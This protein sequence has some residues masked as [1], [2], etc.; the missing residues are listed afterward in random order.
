M[1]VRFF[2]NVREQ[3]EINTNH[4]FIIYISFDFFKREIENPNSD[5][6]DPIASASKKQNNTKL[7]K[8]ILWRI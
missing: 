8:I 1:L 7:H 6:W 3:R 2:Q 5:Q 4:A